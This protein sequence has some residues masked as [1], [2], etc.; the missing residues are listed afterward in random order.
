MDVISEITKIQTKALV[1]ELP[2]AC[3]SVAQKMSWAST[4]QTT[5][6]EDIAYCL[7]GIFDINMP[8]LY[9]EGTKALIRLQEHIITNS[10]DNSIFA[11]C[12]DGG[13]TNQR[14]LALSP[15]LFAKSG[16]IV[17][18]AR[19]CLASKRSLIGGRIYWEASALRLDDPE[20][21]N[22]RHTY[23]VPL[24]CRDLTN[25]ADL[26]IR[27]Q[28]E[29]AHLEDPKKMYMTR[30]QSDIIHTISEPEINRLETQTMSIEKVLRTFPRI[31]DTS[32]IYAR[33]VSRAFPIFPY[34]SHAFP[35]KV[36]R[37]FPISPYES[38]AFYIRC[39]G[40]QR[41]IVSLEVNNTRNGH[42]SE[43]TP[44][45]PSSP[46]YPI[47]GIRLED[48]QGIVFDVILN[49][50]YEEEVPT[51]FIIEPPANESLRDVFSSFVEEM[52]WMEWDESK[53]STIVELSR[54]EP[55]KIW[56]NTSDRFFLR[57]SS[58]ART[59]VAIKKVGP[60]RESFLPADI[61]ESTFERVVMKHTFN[62]LTVR[63]VG[64]EEDHP[65]NYRYLI[66]VKLD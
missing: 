42:Y 24:G 11:W 14:L 55:W 62:A 3:F 63:L 29:P 6:E 50:G 66:E 19:P 34:E 2:L 59:T 52:D 49:R 40:L 57:H 36:P 15:K 16:K 32:H 56:P 9:G 21:Q 8:M 44:K 13:I 20:I 12:D 33:M 53:N 5:R 46:V 35:K 47:L 1:G 18:A 17:R 61:R 41:R 45:P 60:L 37:A 58:G 22:G 26:A 25:I 28:L 7:K 65:V 51:G 39:R 43:K 54:R 38:H 10:E 64:E 23:L 27:L 31:Q 30:I 4:R 48:S